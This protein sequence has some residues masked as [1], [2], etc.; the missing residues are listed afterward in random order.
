MFGVPP[1]RGTVAS[2]MNMVACPTFGAYGGGMYVY[3]YDIGGYGGGGVH[4]GMLG[5]NCTV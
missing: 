2:Q 5:L 3:G 4:V 1:K